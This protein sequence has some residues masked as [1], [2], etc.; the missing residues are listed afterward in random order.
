M[1]ENN[2]ELE[3]ETRKLLG[4]PLGA[5]EN[6]DIAL[7]QSL[8]SQVEAQFQLGSLT[9]G[10]CYGFALECVQK[11]LAAISWNSG[12]RGNNER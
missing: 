11:Y 2:P 7:F 3:T 10:R 12:H 8:A 1:R 4:M 9:D 5:E 6:F